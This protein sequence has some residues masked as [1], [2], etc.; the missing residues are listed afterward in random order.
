[1]ARKEKKKRDPGRYEF[2]MS[3]HVGHGRTQ[4]NF[5]VSRDTTRNRFFV[6]SSPRRKALSGLGF[7]LPSRQLLHPS[8]RIYT[9]LLS[10]SRPNTCL[11]RLFP[12]VHSP[13]PWELELV[14]HGFRTRSSPGS[15][16]T[17][18]SVHVPPISQFLF[19]FTEEH[20]HVPK[21]VCKATTLHL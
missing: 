12:C 7:S 20:V 18:R 11:G 2:T 15:V 4:F 1:M 9:K 19:Y 8:T 6:A 14:F 3:P 17:L 5:P 13:F 21:L 10:L 16:R